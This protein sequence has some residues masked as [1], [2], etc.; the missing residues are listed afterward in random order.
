MWAS[1]AACTRVEAVKR[2]SATFQAMLRQASHL[3]MACCMSLR[4][5]QPAYSTS[6]H[7]M[8]LNRGVRPML[9]AEMEKQ[10]AEQLKQ[11]HAQAAAQAGK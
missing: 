7:S 3:P 10:A 4:H 5:Q 11:L 8:A 1:A 2:A 6:C 9:S